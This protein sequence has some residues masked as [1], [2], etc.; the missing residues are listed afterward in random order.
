MKHLLLSVLCFVF[1][2]PSFAQHFDAWFCDSTLRID[3]QLIGDAHQQHIALDKLNRYPGWAGRR[4]H[5]D[6]L[7]AQGNGQLIVT[8]T[9]GQ[10]VLYQTSF[11]TLFQ[12]W[13]CESEAQHVA[14]S[15]EH[16]MQVPMPKQPVLVKLQL[17]NNRQQT[18]CQFTHR[19]DPT[20]ILIHRIGQENLLPHEVLQQAAHPDKAIHIAILAEGYT[21]EEMPVFYED[22]RVATQSI[23]AHEPFCSLQDRFTVV[24]VA[25]PS[26]QS[27][28]SVPK[29]GEWKQ[30][31][32]GSHF[33][34]FYSDR[35]L[36][37]LN[38]KAIHDALAGI[39][40]EHIIVLAN[41]SEYGGGGIYNNY[42][43]T[44]AHHPKFRPVVVHEFGHSFAALAD[45]Y[46]YG[47]PEGEEGQYPLDVE[48]WESNITTRVDSI[49]ATRVGKIEG[50]GYKT[51]GVF[52]YQ[53]NCRM[54]TNEHPD[55]CPVCEE[56]IRHIIQ[57]YTE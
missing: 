24:A 9:L 28:V 38:L 20:D 57:F 19:V 17:C 39:R 52:R 54:R 45:E 49:K 40:Y 14:R 35:Y 6:E 41:T 22:A 3:Y 21:P 10:Q 25:A 23:F 13:L 36:T 32:F 34:T 37:S 51:K 15:F 12:E 48:P 46:Q 42:N 11:S 4:N 5:L 18:I 31:A 1:A 8:D 55:F 47:T 30:T 16:C 7:A 29:R 44:A 43:L 2:A 27:G 26:A 50:A 53:E 56:Q 33:S